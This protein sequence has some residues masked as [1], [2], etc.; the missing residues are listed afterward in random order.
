MTSCDPCIALGNRCLTEQP[1]QYC[2]DVLQGDKHTI[3]SEAAST[4]EVIIHIGSNDI[5]KGIPQQQIIN[6]VDSAGKRIKE[7]NPNINITLSSIFL[8]AYDTA[9]SINV[10][11]TKL[12]LKHY[13]LSQGWDFIDHSNIAFRHL[14]GDGMHLSPE[15]N[16]LFARNLT[17]HAKSG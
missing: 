17:T 14:D 11:E 4:D 5:S 3:N 16:R 12:A 2:T 10:V 9:K 13:C 15:G 1:L 7:I 8:Q 6:N